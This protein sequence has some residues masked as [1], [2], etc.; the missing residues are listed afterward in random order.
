MNKKIIFDNHEKEILHQVPANYYQNGVKN[1]FLQRK[2]HS[3]KLNAVLD[4]IE[5]EPKNVL[6]VGSASGW[7]LHNINKKY[8]KSKCVG[9]DKYKEA[10][11]YGNKKYKNLKLI[12]ADAHNLP[13]KAGSFDLII[14]TE[15]LEH[16]KDPDIVLKEIKRVLSKK[17]DAIIEMDSGNI[18]FR[19]AWYWW[20]NLRRGVWMDSHL[21]V[22]N[23][24]K[25]ERII[26]KSGL[27]IKRRKVF[28]Y[29]MGV[30]FLLKKE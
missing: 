23:I 3:G 12:Y 14:C 28:N 25:L 15:V 9:I 16:V 13:F 24:K 29:S 17:G 5:N 21:H 22:F 7:F 26:K 27:K 11:V 30:A 20:T 4:L 6:D 8:P 18:L 2:W 10:V 19:A 1:N